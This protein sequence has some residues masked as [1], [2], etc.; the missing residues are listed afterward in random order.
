[1]AE[2]NEEQYLDELLNSLRSSNTSGEND[3][4]QDSE[5]SA[6][7]T[8]I[9]LDDGTEVIDN[10]G[11]E[12]GLHDDIGPIIDEPQADDIGPIID[13]PQADDI[14]PII[15]E[16][17]ADDIGPII[18]ESPADDEVPPADGQPQTEDEPVNEAPSAGDEADENTSGESSSD[19]IF[20]LEDNF[21]ISDE[22]DESAAGT[23]EENQPDDVPLALTEPDDAQ[24]E[25]TTESI[26][27][28]DSDDDSDDG[29][30]QLLNQING[31][32]G[33]H[34][35]K[36]DNAA[37][38]DKSHNETKA[39]DA[40]SDKAAREEEK[41]RKKAE[42]LAKKEQRR[43]EKEEKKKNKKHKTDNNA[44]EQTDESAADDNINSA[45][46]ENID[47]IN[48]LYSDTESLDNA[49]L[50]DDLADIP[51]RDAEEEEPEKPK[52]EKKKK[53]PKPKKPK[54]E[55][56]KKEKK[57]P[58]PSELVKVTPKTFLGIIIF[59][60]VI[61]V[62]VIFGTKIVNYSV[63]VKHAIDHFNNGKYDQAYDSIAGL[64]VKDKDKDTYYKIRTVM[65]VYVDY[66]SYIS[67][68]QLGMNVEALDSLIRGLGHYDDYYSDAEKYDVVAQY[69]GVKDKITAALAQY[70]VSEEDARYYAGLE[71]EQQ[72][73][74]IL[75]NIGGRIR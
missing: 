58:K 36:P 40:K 37:G 61:T 75:N 64:E 63:S 2:N 13:E 21:D 49:P 16:P 68:K 39:K 73:E 38:A 35:E 17:Q 55:K 18:D 5:K 11:A 7:D 52:K 66:T 59:A 12:N 45:S 69:D 50:G 67:Y 28:D 33:K 19:D 14:G 23:D 57:A 6:V 74:E 8:D 25:K 53:E 44:S 72:Y 29:L 30:M 70:G 24:P 48:E 42:K 26:G 20:A 1:V 3:V 56:V 54:K 15:D 10:A 62:V 46:Q 22:N 32:D 65:S 4:E 27:Q 31:E 9:V 47:L 71:S 51:E 41:E 60:V 34:E 43:K